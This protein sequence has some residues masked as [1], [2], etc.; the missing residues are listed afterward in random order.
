MNHI[1]GQLKSQNSEK[2]E[3]KINKEKTTR[4]RIQLQA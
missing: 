1:Y 4:N 2:L 3:G